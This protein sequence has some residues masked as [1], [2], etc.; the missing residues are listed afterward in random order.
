MTIY[1]AWLLVPFGGPAAEDL[2]NKWTYDGLIVLAFVICALRAI[3]VAHERAAFVVL[4]T[5]LGSWATGE[6]LYSFAYGSEPPY[7]SAADAFYLAFYP[8]AYVALLLLVR[9]RSRIGGSVWLDGV[10]GALAAG[11]LGAAVIFQAVLETTEGSAA[12]VITNLAYPLGDVLLL[13]VVVG[14]TA[15][16]GWRPG[17]G[18]IVIGAALAATAVGDGIYLFQSANGTYV[19]GSILDA[20]WPASVLLLAWAGWMRGGAIPTV[21]L[22][23]RPLL[24][25][26]AI[27]GLVGLG[28]LVADHFHPLNLLALVL[29]I[30]AVVAVFV[31]TGLTFVENG[32]ILAHVRTQAATDPLT[33][34]GNRRQLLA[35]LT[36]VTDTHPEQH[37]LIIFDLDGFKNY[38]DTFGHLAGDALL[39]RL[40]RRLAA[41]VAP[42]GSAYR[43]GGDEFSVLSRVP[44]EGAESLLEQTVRALSDEGEGFAVTSSFGAVYLGD[45]ASDPREA[46]RIADNR[47]YAQKRMRSVGRDKPHQVLLQAISEREPL[48]RAHVRSVAD[49]SLAAGR[50]LGV[51]PREL[52]RL[53]L[54]AELHDVGKLAIPDEV[55]SKPGALD[56]HEWAFIRE[57]TVVGQRILS[58]SPALHDVAAIVRAT[59]ERWDGTGYPGGVA[60]EAIP[61]AARIIFVCDAL[62]AMTADRPYR[63]TK[64]VAEAVAELRRCAGTQFDPEIVDVVCDLVASGE[65]VLAF[66][67]LDADATPLGAQPTSAGAVLVETD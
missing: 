17:R 35:E 52:D 31:R 41:V 61:L 54:A 28:L 15:L 45:E 13:A 21:E 33:G 9:S 37:M 59:H 46:L 42:H 63:P 3:C 5:G 2:F 27:C 40:G 57:H 39:T 58:A 62:A 19:E 4:A 1:V 48:L 56:N 29:A 44:A 8:C 25:T 12:V 67:V 64:S 55:L 50:Q 20:L 18:W 6:V 51:E 38:N 7:P 49:L 53:R 11:A 60:G 16:S 30:G 36:R 22:E 34:L 66:P 24:A 65:G 14:V 23:G 32:R 43:L 26:P 10:M 47:L